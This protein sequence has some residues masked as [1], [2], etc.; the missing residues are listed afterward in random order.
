MSNKKR[1]Q[2]RILEIELM[3]FRKFFDS[4]KNFVSFYEEWKERQKSLKLVSGAVEPKG[5]ITEEG[6]EMIVDITG[7]FRFNVDENVRKIIN[8]SNANTLNSLKNLGKAIEKGNNNFLE[9]LKSIKIEIPKQRVG[10]LGLEK[11]KDGSVKTVFA[12]SEDYKEKL[13]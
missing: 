3:R 10:F 6:K 8:D 13:P 11:Q 1:I 4:M 9:N 12:G 5:L 2:K 7:N